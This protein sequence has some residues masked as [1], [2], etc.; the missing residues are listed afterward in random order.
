[1]VATVEMNFW[2]PNTARLD[3]GQAFKILGLLA[4]CKKTIRERT[5]RLARRTRN[6][7]NC[8]EW[9]CLHPKLLRNS[10]PASLSWLLKGF[11]T[12]SQDCKLEV[13]QSIAVYFEGMGM[14]LTASTGRSIIRWGV[15]RDSIIL[16]QTR[17]I[18]VRHRS[19]LIRARVD[20]GFM[21]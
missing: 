3:L 18:K 13:C 15:E 6:I 4:G 8:R 2:K 17:A 10:N 19:E 5:W 1:V 9:W 14:E 21:R 20:L 11:R 16:R 12:R 7:R